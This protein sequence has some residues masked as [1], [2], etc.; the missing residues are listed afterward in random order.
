MTI[1]G[2]IIVTLLGQTAMKRSKTVS[3]S[4][5]QFGQLP[6]VLINPRSNAGRAI[7]GIWLGDPQDF[8][9]DGTTYRWIAIV[10]YVSLLN[11]GNSE[12]DETVNPDT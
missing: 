7:S 12:I 2:Q 1:E 11:W 6:T 5:N 10:D 9:T 8:T 4:M 3:L